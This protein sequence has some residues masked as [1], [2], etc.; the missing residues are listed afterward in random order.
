MTQQQL[1]QT[2]SIDDTDALKHKVDEA[3]AVYDEYVKAQTEP[4]EGEAEN[5]EVKT[6]A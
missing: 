6:E 3:M 2:R 1:T 4:T 5:T